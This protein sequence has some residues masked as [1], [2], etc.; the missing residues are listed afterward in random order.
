[1]H[2]GSNVVL[3]LLPAMVIYCSNE[4]K[5]YDGEP[6]G[7]VCRIHADAVSSVRDGATRTA[8]GSRNSLLKERM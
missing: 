8:F 7:T 3:L 4:N 6:Y 1:L 5:S 2:I